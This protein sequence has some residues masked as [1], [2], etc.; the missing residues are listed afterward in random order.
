MK[1]RYDNSTNMKNVLFLFALFLYSTPCLIAQNP[2]IL[3]IIADD[4]GVDALNGYNVGSI[5]PNTPHLDSLRNSG[6]NFTNAWAAPVC[7]PTRAGMLSGLYGSKNGVKSVPGNLDTSH[8]SLFRKLKA[9]NPSYTVGVSGKWH[10]TMP[11]NVL[12]PYLHGTDHYMGV[13]EGAVSAYDN[14][15][16]TEGN[17]TNSSTDYV[18]SYFTDD[19][20]GWIN[21]Q[22]NP[23]FMWLAHVA[24][25]TP[26]HVP[27]AHMFTQAATN[28]LFQ[29]YLAMVESLD[30]EVGRLLDSLTPDQ[31]ANT[32]IIF[33]GD[34]G[35]PNN[36]LQ[37]YPAMHGK[38]SLYQGGVHVPMFVSGYGVARI[39]ESEDALINVI[40][41]Y[42]TVLELTGSELPGGINNSLSFKHLLQSSE[43]PKRQYNFSELDSNLLTIKTQGF[44]IRNTT[45]K[46]IEYHTGQQE[47]FNLISDKL[48]TNNLLLG[49]LTSDEESIKLDLE[50]EADQRRNSWSCKDDIQNG[51]EEGIDCGGSVCNPCGSALP[52]TGNTS[53]MIEVFPNPSDNSIRILAESEKMV[54]IR[55]LNGVGKVILSYENVNARSFKLDISG[56]SPNLYI[57]NLD[58]STHTVTRKILVQ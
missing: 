4:L 18:T 54:G 22:N 56:L 34:N 33:I 31:K 12:H 3:L 58:F 41:I 17:T 25:H 2:N 42:A 43:L 6:L 47:L 39:G 29:Q 16:K 48:E 10:I 30:Y 49:T 26:L 14:W 38:A 40:D 24:P 53:A 8:T 11:V 44:A 28:S 35:S 15:E 36:V 7:S 1:F 5:K 9:V 57:L 50:L 55:V 13:I 37:D 23:W 32:T 19:A 46:L 20:I 45:Y 51:D 27:P 52:G 21:N